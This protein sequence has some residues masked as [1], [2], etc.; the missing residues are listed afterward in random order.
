[1]N[2]RFLAQD[3]CNFGAGTGGS[4]ISFP[5]RLYALRF[6]GQ[7]LH[8]VAALQLMAER[9]ELVIYFRTDTVAADVCVQGKSEIQCCRVLRHGLDFAFRSKYE[10]FRSKQIQ[11]DGIQKINGVRLGVVEYL[12]D[13]TQPFIQLALILTATA[14]FVFPMGG[15]A[16]LRNVVHTLAANLNFNPLSVIPHKGDVQGLITIG[17]RVAHPVA[18]A[19]GMRFVYFGYGHVYVEAVVQLL[20]HI[21]GFEDDA[22]GQQ[23]IDFLK[24]HVLGLHLVPDRVNGFYAG[25]NAVFQS[26]LIQLGAY[27]SGE[28]FEYLVA[29]Y[30][31]CRQIF[32]NFAVLFRMF[33]PET[34]VFQL[35]LYLV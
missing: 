32:F 5:F 26:H 15:E 30:G 3:G 4:G 10:N 27:R 33:V 19:V 1:M 24:R 11:L 17:F 31:C 18:Q 16:L 2:F 8:L 13:G 29:L 28:F 22:Y 12:L 14:F 23:V 25:E 35:R 34:Q 6:G 20:F 21:A 7:N 9:N